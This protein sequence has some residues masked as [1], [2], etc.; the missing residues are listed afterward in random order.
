MHGDDDLEA[1]ADRVLELRG[2]DAGRTD[3]AAEGSIFDL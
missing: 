1:M 3:V 2:P